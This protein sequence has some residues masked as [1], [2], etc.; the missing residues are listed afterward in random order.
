LKIFI[1]PAFVGFIFSFFVGLFGG[2]AAQKTLFF[3]YFVFFTLK[4][5]L[6]QKSY[7]QFAFLPSNALPVGVSPSFPLFFINPFQIVVS[8]DWKE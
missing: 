3:S 5:P 6:S 2:F 8:A 1:N 4:N 7:Q